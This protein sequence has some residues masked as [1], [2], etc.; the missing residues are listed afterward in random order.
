[1][2]WLFADALESMASGHP[3]LTR[4]APHGTGWIQH[5]A[6]H[7]TWVFYLFYPIAALFGGVTAALLWNPFFLTLGGVVL[8]LFA[9]RVLDPFRALLLTIAYFVCQW[10]STALSYDTHFETAYPFFVFLLM[11]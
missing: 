9:R 1:D 2:F 7:P 5:G 11:Y 6:V 8:G 4:F 10:I 3:F